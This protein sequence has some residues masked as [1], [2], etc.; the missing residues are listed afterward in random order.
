MLVVVISACSSWTTYSKV[1]KGSVCF[2]YYDDYYN[3]EKFPYYPIRVDEKG[4]CVMEGCKK[5]RT[6][7]KCNSCNKFM[8]NEPCFG[9]YHNT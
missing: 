1:Y 8:C 6:I 5:G 2:L 3:K 9:Q 7:Y 4:S